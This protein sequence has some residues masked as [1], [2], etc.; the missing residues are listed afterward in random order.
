MKKRQILKEKEQL[1]SKLTKEIEE[2][3]IKVEELKN[4]YSKENSINSIDK[5]D[6]LDEFEL[7]DS[8]KNKNITLTSNTTLSENQTRILAEGEETASSEEKG[9]VLPSMEAGE[10]IESL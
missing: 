1:A 10:T 7:E 5:N 8:N 3:K 2:L 9:L 4:H 6:D